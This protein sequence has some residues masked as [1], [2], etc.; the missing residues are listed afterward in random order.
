L[1]QGNHAQIRIFGAA[2]QRRSGQQARTQI[3]G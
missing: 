2:R 3:G 1:P